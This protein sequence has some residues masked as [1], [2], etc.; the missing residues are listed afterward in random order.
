MLQA[1][2]GQEKKSLARFFFGS[3]KGKAKMKGGE[4]DPKD[5]A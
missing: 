3:A 4:K 2:A 5:E 1:T